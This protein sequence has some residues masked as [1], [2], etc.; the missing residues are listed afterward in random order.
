MAL[1][2]VVVVDD[3]EA[4][5]RDLRETIAGEEGIEI[6]G[7][8]ASAADG[9][10]EVQRTGPDVVL[11]D[12][13]LPDGSGVEFCRDLGVSAPS[14]RC[15]ILTSYDDDA[16]IG[17]AHAVG[18]GGYVIKDAPGSDIVRAIREL[19]QARGTLDPTVAALSPQERRILTLIGEGLTNREIAG[20]TYLAEKTVKNYVSS[21]LRKLGMQHRSQAASLAA[22]AGL[23]GAVQRSA[24]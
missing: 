22:R 18:A 6:V 19:A 2:K 1:I 4:F 13:R 15:L 23:P 10:R 24:H 8:A 16:I 12:V 7:E 11:V 5:K 17:R 20:Q 21:L 14:A 3:H 9:L